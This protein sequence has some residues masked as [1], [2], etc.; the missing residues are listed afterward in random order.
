VTDDRPRRPFSHLADVQSRRR[1]DGDLVKTTTESTY[2]APSRPAARPQPLA[3][4][5]GPTVPNLEAYRRELRSHCTRVLG[6]TFEADDAVQETMVR[7]WRNFD[8]FEGRAALRTWLYRI[9]TNICRDM[10]RSSQRRA[11][12]LAAVPEDSGIDAPALGPGAGSVAGIR[13]WPPA[14][15]S[16]SAADPAS[17]RAS[18]PADVAMAREA[19]RA[20]VV[21][22]LHHLPPRQRAALI[23][24]EVLRWR[25]DEIADL[26]GSTVPA[27]NSALQ[28]ARATLAA[29]DLGDWGEGPGEAPD[30]AERSLVSRFVAAFEHTDMDALVVL[31]QPVPGTAAAA[32]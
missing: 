19:V 25:A 21:A 8:R 30:D 2:T 31:L 32:S 7:A 29:T 23:L 16:T 26:L 15:G 27:V 13:S 5:H 17:G 9:A 24:R 20:A 14:G 18:D 22:A 1:R 28:R 11:R 3:P 12:P 4:R 6:S 10:L